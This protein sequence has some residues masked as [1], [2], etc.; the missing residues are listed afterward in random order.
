MKFPIVGGGDKAAAAPPF[1]SAAPPRRG[2]LMSFPV[3]PPAGIPVEALGVT[4]AP[5]VPSKQHP[6]PRPQR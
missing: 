2:H 1:S 6:P 5:C 4:E 3:D